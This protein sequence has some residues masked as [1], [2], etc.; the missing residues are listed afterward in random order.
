MS[1]NEHVAYPAVQEALAWLR[2]AIADGRLDEFSAS[3]QEAIA[4]IIQQVQD[5]NNPGLEL[6]DRKWLADSILRDEAALY[7]KIQSRLNLRDIAPTPED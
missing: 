6:A 2:E 7:F 4:D 5:L 3:E 1:D